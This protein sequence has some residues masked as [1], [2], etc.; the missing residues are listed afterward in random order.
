M[1]RTSAHT[2]KKLAD[3]ADNLHE[4]T[5]NWSQVY[6]GEWANDKR[7]G[8]GILKVSDYFTYYGQWKD[9]IRTG[10][11]VLVHEGRKDKKKGGKKEEVEEGRW[12]NGKLVEPIKHSKIPLK[13]KNDLQMRVEEA[14]QVAIKAAAEARDKAKVAETKAN[15]AAAKS[16]VA[17]MRANEARQ[18]AESASK[19]VESA[20]MISKQAMEDACRIKGGVKIIINEP[21]GELAT[22]VCEAYC[23]N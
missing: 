4:T 8:H 12:E 7:S 10:Y 3:S 17:E 20:A 14:H 16:K 13:G 21:Y 2:S 22:G 15:A 9:N 6:E 11:G 1:P 19:G 5:V 23:K 18:H